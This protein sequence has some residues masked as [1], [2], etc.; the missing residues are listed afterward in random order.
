MSAADDADV[1]YRELASHYGTLTPTQQAALRRA[2]E[3]R[4]LS[5]IMR[6][7]ALHGAPDVTLAD[8]T[9]AEQLAVD[10]LRDL[11]LPAPPPPPQDRRMEIV[12][13]RPPPDALSTQND[14][15]RKRIAELESKLRASEN[16]AR[17]ARSD[18][19]ELQGE[20]N[21]AKANPPKPPSIFTPTAIVQQSN[22][23]L[24]NSRYLF[25]GGQSLLEW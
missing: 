19:Q 1:V 10:A 20:L 24:W 22:A 8:L 11:D 2:A 7:A 9:R 25:G 23:E 5:D 4:A 12:L 15:L 16:D 21:A 13:V 14:E 18:A 6:R 17:T 3:L